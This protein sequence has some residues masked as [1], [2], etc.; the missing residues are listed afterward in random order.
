VMRVALIQNDGFTKH[1]LTPEDVAANLD[2]VMDMS[3]AHE[4]KVETLLS[5]VDH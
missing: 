2:K 3:G 4:V 1:D 5:E